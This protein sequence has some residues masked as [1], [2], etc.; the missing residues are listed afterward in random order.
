MTHMSQVYTLK[1]ESL[2]LLLLNVQQK[3]NAVQFPI[4]V[5]MLFTVASKEMGASWNS[6][7]PF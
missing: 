1:A 3:S 4:T 7:L 2:S 5:G 6:I